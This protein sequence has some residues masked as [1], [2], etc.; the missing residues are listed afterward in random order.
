MC[1]Y[2][3]ADFCYVRGSACEMNSRVCST[4][5]EIANPEHILLRVLR[6]YVKCSVAQLVSASDC[7][8]IRH[9]SYHQEVESSTL[10]GAVFFW[11]EFILH[12]SFFFWLDHPLAKQGFGAI[13]FLAW[14]RGLGANIPRCRSSPTAFK[15]RLP[16]FQK[17]PSKTLIHTRP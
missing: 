7:Y 12:P 5:G 4:T 8:G 3:I 13:L 17:P 16:L 14:F 1:L 2:L 9:G 15:K 11:G 6:R 10:S